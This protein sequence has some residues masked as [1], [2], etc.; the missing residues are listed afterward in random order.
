MLN[1]AA[2][3]QRRISTH[4]CVSFAVVVVV[5][6]S[7]ISLSSTAT[8]ALLVIAVLGAFTNERRNLFYTL[9]V[10]ED[11]KQRSAAQVQ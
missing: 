2:I 8:T 10:R 1:C 9:L 5:P 3:N 11:L 4:S 6:T 7:K